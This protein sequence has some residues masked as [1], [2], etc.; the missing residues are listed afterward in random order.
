MLASTFSDRPR[1]PSSL[2]R[3]IPSRQIRC[4]P[5]PVSPR[6]ARDHAHAEEISLVRFRHSM[7]RLTFVRLCSHTNNVSTASQNT[8]RNLESHAM[9]PAEPFDLTR[10]VG[11]GRIGILR[12]PQRLAQSPRRK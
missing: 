2:R 4:L 9:T 3:R 6:T 5:P 7:F 10:V 11:G 12:D 8:I 1:S